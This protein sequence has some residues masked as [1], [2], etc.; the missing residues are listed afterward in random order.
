[1]R[2][3]SLAGRPKTRKSGATVFN[4]NAPKEAIDTTQS[5]PAFASMPTTLATTLPGA[6]LSIDIGRGHTG[7]Y[8]DPTPLLR[9]LAYAITVD[10]HEKL[11]VE[12]TRIDAK[13]A[14]AREE[15]KARREQVASASRMLTMQSGIF[16]A[17]LENLG[18]AEAKPY[19]PAPIPEGLADNQISSLSTFLEEFSIDQRQLTALWRTFAIEDRPNEIIVNG[20]GLKWLLAVCVAVTIGAAIYYSHPGFLLFSAIFAVAALYLHIT[21]IRRRNAVARAFERAS[22]QTQSARLA[23]SQCKKAIQTRCKTHQAAT[24]AYVKNLEQDITLDLKTLQNRYDFRLSEIK[25]YLDNISENSMPYLSGLSDLVQFEGFVGNA[26]VPFLR[27]GSMRINNDIVGRWLG[28][29]PEAF[30]V[31]GPKI[32]PLADSSPLGLEE[33][34]LPLSTSFAPGPGILLRGGAS[35]RKQRVEALQSIALRLLSSIRPGRMRFTLIDP[36]GLGESFAL[37]MALGDYG[38]VLIGSRAWTEPN[39]IEQQLAD[40]TQHMETVIQKYLRADFKTIEEYNVHVGQVVEPYR[41]LVVS[42][43]PTGFS[44]IA[45]KRL[46]SIVQ[47]GPRCGVFPVISMDA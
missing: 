11:G 12:T 10:I 35:T 30:L 15:A 13:A 39:Q 43:F 21:A 8:L 31:N 19:Q 18:Q 16:E 27:L 17:W 29:A 5:G 40:L 41:I 28:G 36:V 9:T 20:E 3:R 45:A 37:I 42:D 23:W 1:M 44:D 2:I 32:C 26:T 24:E 22:T 46:V 4:S 34:D 7:T 14:T 33:L 6:E 25:K 38:E 47:N